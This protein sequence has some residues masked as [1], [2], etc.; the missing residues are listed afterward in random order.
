M[1]P[2][3]PVGI[4]GQFAITGIVT[5]LELIL[6]AVFASILCGFYRRIVLPQDASG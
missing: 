6:V 2:I 1:M 4:A 5:V 3:P